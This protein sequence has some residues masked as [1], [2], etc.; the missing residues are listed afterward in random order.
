M[1]KC[2]TL[3]NNKGGVGKTSLACSLALHAANR[4]YKV[5]LCDLDVQG[6][7][8]RG[9]NV[10]ALKVEHTVMDMLLL[11]AEPRECVTKSPL[12]DNLF[13]LPN[14]ITELRKVNEL[15]AMTYGREAR[16]A[17]FLRGLE[18]I[19]DLVVCDTPPFLNVMTVNGLVASDYIVVPVVPEPFA[20]MGLGHLCSFL[21]KVLHRNVDLVAVLMAG[22]RFRLTREIKQ[23]LKSRFGDVVCDVV[24]P[25]S[26]KI[27]ELSW[28][29]LPPVAGPRG[30]KAVEGYYQLCEVILRELAKK[31]KR[32]DKLGKET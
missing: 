26:I 11:R 18:G 30:N 5:L 29:G 6:N 13:V 20:L 3:C 7:A 21:D 32:G 27:P 14:R 31:P 16:L 25:R 15:Y 22:E 4:G 10:D 2:V 17:S 24:V 1:V 12:N 9:V 23:E 19:V 28:A 8:T